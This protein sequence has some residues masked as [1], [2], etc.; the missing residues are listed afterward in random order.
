[1]KLYHEEKAYLEAFKKKVTSDADISKEEIMEMIT[2]FEDVVEMTTVTVKIIDRL[3]N[4]IDRLK[5]DTQKEIASI[6]KP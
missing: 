5:Q 3:M 1:M 4:N 6:K 2:K